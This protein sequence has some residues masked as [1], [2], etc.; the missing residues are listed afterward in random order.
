MNNFLNIFTLY[1]S[2]L[3]RTIDNLSGVYNDP[4][5]LFEAIRKVIGDSL[6]QSSIEGKKILLKPNW[7]K[8][9]SGQYDEICLRTNDN[10]LLATLEMILANRP[11]GVIIG[12]APIQGGVWDEIVN[13]KLFEKINELGKKYDIPVQV[14]DFRRAIFYSG[15]NKL[16]TELN[17]LSDYLIFD[18]KDQSCLESVTEKGRNIFR[19]T[20][21]DP[22]KL[23]ESHKPGTHKYCIIKEFFKADLI[24]SLPKIKTHQKSGLTGALKNIVGLNGDKDF[25]PHHRIGGTGF[26]GDCYPGGNHLRYWSEIAMDIANS[27]R[28]K[29]KYLLWVKIASIFWKLSFPKAVHNIEAGWYGNDTTW[30][31]VMD[32]NQ[33]AYFGKPD[34]TISDTKQRDI[35]SLCDGIIAGQGDGPLKPEPLQLGVISF[36]D[37]PALNDIAMATL[38]GFDI[39][40][41]PLLT[42]ATKLIPL[43]GAEVYINETKGS[44]SELKELSVRTNPPRGW[45][46]FLHEE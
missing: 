29:N 5:K 41:F 1:D 14:K 42:E 25:L 2:L 17:P 15:K 46:S 32:L 33:I 45:K 43:N 24:L 6:S 36:T 37:N 22:L 8:H 10:F 39:K 19:V 21:Y 3:D 11:S 23:E 35:Y 20:D 26:G 31:M 38:M 12:D 9:S 30:R 34:G 4:I 27:H 44:V 28:G 7:V 16:M 40:K 13:V 18:L